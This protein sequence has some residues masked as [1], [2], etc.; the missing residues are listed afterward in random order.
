[1]YELNDL[2]CC[3]NCNRFIVEKNKCN[4]SNNIVC[5]YE[6]CEN[7]I[8]DKLGSIERSIIHDQ[9]LENHKKKQDEMMYHKEK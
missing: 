2:K 1:M 8:W 6:S 7:W 5:G 3:G 9:D 4:K